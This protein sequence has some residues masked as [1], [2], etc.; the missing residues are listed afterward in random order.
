MYKFLQWLLSYEV[1]P[2]TLSVFDFWH[3]FYLFLI[4]GFI[5]VIV[6]K[7]KNKDD[8][9]KKRMI[10]IVINIAFGLYILDFFL[11][12]FSYGYID[13]DK[14]PFHICTAT[15]VLIP[16]VTFNKKFSCLKNV[17]TTWAIFGPLLWIILPMGVL[18]SANRLYSYPIVQS[19]AY[20]VIELFWGVFMLTSGNV[21]LEWRKI[22]QQKR[23]DGSRSAANGQRR[24]KISAKSRRQSC[25]RMLFIHSRDRL[26]V[27]VLYFG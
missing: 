20:H 21:K 22:W 11:M 25:H 5:V 26:T 1:G 8:L 18:N 17:V 10:N 14:L 23:P 19:Y 2:I 13:I 12:P 3:I 6:Y 15:G 27:T 9:I 24:S 4:F 7:F 16:F